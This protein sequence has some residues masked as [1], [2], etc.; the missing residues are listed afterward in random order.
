[1]ISSSAYGTEEMLLIM[2]PIIGVAAFSMV[3]PITLAILAVML[4]VMSSYMQVIGVYTR[5]GGSYVVA[6]SSG[7]RISSGLPILRRSR[8]VACSG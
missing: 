4:F 1:M 3:I 7:A 6:R 5:N 8:S 2:V